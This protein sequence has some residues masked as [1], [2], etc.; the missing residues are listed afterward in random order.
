MVH[1]LVPEQYVY[2]MQRSSFFSSPS[3]NRRCLE[4]AP[5][6]QEPVSRLR[7]SLPH[8][9]VSIPTYLPDMAGLTKMTQEGVY[10]P[11]IAMIVTQILKEQFVQ[12]DTVSPIIALRVHGIGH[13]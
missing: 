7:L 8:K 9:P 11:F 12:L 10:I 3:T 2:Y 1:R 6:P 5:Q 13:I 4:S